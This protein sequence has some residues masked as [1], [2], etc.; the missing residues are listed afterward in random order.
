MPETRR[1]SSLREA[2]LALRRG[3]PVEILLG[4]CGEN[5]V[6]FAQIAE[7]ADGLTLW[8]QERRRTGPDFLDLY[9]AEPLDDEAG[10]PDGVA[11]EGTFENLDALIADLETR[12]PD[13]N[14]GMV[15]FGVVADE[16]LDFLKVA[17]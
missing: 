4:A 16:H 14:Y 11:F 8:V 9:E 15:N 6:R 7:T 1:H 5:G 12:Y 17:R 13:Q 2:N 10:N 3:R